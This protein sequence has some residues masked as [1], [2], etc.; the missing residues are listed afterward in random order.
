MLSLRLILL[1]SSLLLV[2]GM[3]SSLMYL[4]ALRMRR[5]REAAA[6]EVTGPD[7]DSPA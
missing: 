2:L 3:V 4:A 7:L 5:E 6:V 1:T